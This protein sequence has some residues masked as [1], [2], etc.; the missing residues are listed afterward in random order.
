MNTTDHLREQASAPGARTHARHAD[1]TRISKPVDP[2]G[3]G[4]LEFLDGPPGLAGS[5]QFGLVQAVDGL[6]QRVVVGLT[7]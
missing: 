1:I 5:D 3:G 6:G 2:F 7:G 4:Q